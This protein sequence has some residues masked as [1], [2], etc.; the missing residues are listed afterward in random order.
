MKANLRD[1]SL[2]AERVSLEEEYRS[3]KALRPVFIGG[4]ARSGTTLLLRLLDGHERLLVYPSENWTLNRFLCV[5][6]RRDFDIPRFLRAMAARDAETLSSLVLNATTANPFSNPLRVYFE[7]RGARE[8]FKR[9]F[10]QTLSSVQE[11]WSVSEV[12]MTH[13]FSYFQTAGVGAMSQYQGWV[14]KCPDGGHCLPTY[15][16][17]FPDCRIIYT[18]RDPRAIYASQHHWHKEGLSGW[19][20]ISFVFN[21]ADSCKSAFSRV[22]RVLD[23]REENLLLVGYEGLVESPKKAMKKV[24]DFLGIAF[25]EILLRPTCMNE[26]CVANS[27]FSE[28]ENSPGKIFVSSSTRWRHLMRWYERWLIEAGLAGELVEWGYEERIRAGMVKKLLRGFIRLLQRCQRQGGKHS[29][30][31]RN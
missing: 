13:I 31:D 4:H 11:R 16:M 14:L 10:L 7:D 17:M 24:A 28:E 1:R 29:I 30:N 21:L 26:L 22:R 19:D 2:L 15:N 5:V 3:F 27:S 6:A 18:I 12:L 20:T 8:R 9:C 25:H 23:R